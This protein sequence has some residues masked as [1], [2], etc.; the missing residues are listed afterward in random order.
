MHIIR[1]KLCS[2]YFYQ[3]CPFYLNFF[4]FVLFWVLHV[5]CTQMKMQTNISMWLFLGV[6]VFLKCNMF[7]SALNYTHLN[8]TMFQPSPHT[9]TPTK[10]YNLNLLESAAINASAAG[11]QLL[12]LPEL[13]LSGYNL[14]LINTTY[15][16]PITGFSHCRMC[17]FDLLC[18]MHCN[19]FFRTIV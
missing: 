19:V 15:F 6:F 8:V 17:K 11:S 1:Y 4:R 9:L 18:I 16:E 13:F 7:C 2:R 5:C 3:H 14:N 10:E 12:I